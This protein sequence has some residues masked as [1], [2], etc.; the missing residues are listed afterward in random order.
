VLY[1]AV[2][3]VALRIGAIDVPYQAREIRPPS[4]QHIVIVIAHHAPRTTQ[5]PWH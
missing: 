1:H 2:A 3:I 4:A 5:I